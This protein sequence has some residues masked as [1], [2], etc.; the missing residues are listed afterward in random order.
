MLGLL[1]VIS[2]LLIPCILYIEK[3]LCLKMCHCY[4]GV[5]YFDFIVFDSDYHYTRFLNIF[6]TFVVQNELCNSN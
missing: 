6:K 4:L 3:K 2:C 5:S 1:Q